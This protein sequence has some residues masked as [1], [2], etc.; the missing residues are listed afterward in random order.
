K[1]TVLEK[2]RLYPNVALDLSVV[3]LNNQKLSLEQSLELSPERLQSV[4]RASPESLQRVS[5]ASP[6]RLQR[7]TYET[8]P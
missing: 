8:K 4:S 6:E 3:N 2:E 5:R 1:P 7:R